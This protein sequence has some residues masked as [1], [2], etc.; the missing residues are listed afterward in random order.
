VPLGIGVLV[1]GCGS[2]DKKDTTATSAPK[3]TKTAAKSASPAA[4]GKTSNLTLSA[5]PSGALKFTVKQLKTKAGSV[6]LTMDNPSDVA[7]AIAVEGNG[8]DKDGQTVTK[9]GKSTV[10]A[11]L[12][13]GKYEFYCPVDAHKQQGMEGSLTVT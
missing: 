6:T 4:G 7:H 1:A 11:D 8:V 2:S 5:D 13:P 10:T 12:K 9:G 3:N